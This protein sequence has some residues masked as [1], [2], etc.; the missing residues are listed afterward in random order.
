MSKRHDEILALRAQG[1]SVRE[2]ASR[3]GIST[4]A[5]YHHVS[6]R[7][8]PPPEP[9]I[10]PRG[11]MPEPTPGRRVGPYDRIIAS[12]LALKED[13]CMRIPY[14]CAD[15]KVRRR[16]AS[17]IRGALKERKIRVT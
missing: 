4:P 2:I 8:G 7:N 9:S 13:E 15:S 17:A 10:L 14:P 12:V 3:L 11:Q 1:M 6:A 16:W 5:V